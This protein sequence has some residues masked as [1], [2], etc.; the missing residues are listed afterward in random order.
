MKSRISIAAAVVGLVLLATPVLG[1]GSPS[2][3]PTPRSTGLGQAPL[4]SCMARESAVKNRMQSLT[5]LATNMEKVFDSIALRVED[6]YT[7]K[8]LPS[9]KTLSTYDKLIADISTKKGIVDTDLMSASDM[10]SS[11][12]CSSDDPR[13]LLLNFRIKMQKVKSDLK[14]YRT[15]I[16]NLIV[17][18][19][20]LAPT[21]APTATP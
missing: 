11:F 7:L 19:R 14:D 5:N 3:F 10:V 6:F 1:Q 9:G 13:G 2:P 16:K 12:N 8:V 18:V 15:S 20:P 21:P 4:K 17:A